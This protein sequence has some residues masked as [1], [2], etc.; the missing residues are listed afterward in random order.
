[1]P[2][3]IIPAIIPAITNSANNKSQGVEDVEI[4]AAALDTEI[5]LAPSALLYCSMA[6]F[7]RARADEAEAISE[8]REFST[9][10]VFSGSTDAVD[11]IILRRLV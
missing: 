2:R 8:V 9:Y 11:A 10:S 7:A 4:I 5:A 6:L 3:A 1:M